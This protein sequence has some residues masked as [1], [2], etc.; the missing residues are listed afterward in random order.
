VKINKVVEEEMKIQSKTLVRRSKILSIM[1]GKG[2][3]EEIET[4]RINQNEQNLN[5]VIESLEKEY[6]GT[7]LLS[8]SH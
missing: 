5:R 3:I 6:N 4:D 1:I 2:L 7:D 8:D